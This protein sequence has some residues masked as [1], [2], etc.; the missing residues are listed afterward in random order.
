MKKVLLPFL[1]I[2][3]FLNAHLFSQTGIDRPE[4]WKMVEDSEY[5]KSVVKIICKEKVGDSEF[6]IGSGSG[7]VI[8]K[9][10][11]QEGCPE[12]WY[13]GWILTAGHV[14]DCAL[15][16]IEFENG[17]KSKNATMLKMYNKD[18]EKHGHKE[19][20]AI[21]RAAIPNSIKP[22]KIAKDYPPLYSESHILGFGGGSDKVR[23]FMFKIGISDDKGTCILGYCM[24]GDSG[25]PILNENGEI[26]SL[27]SSVAYTDR[28]ERI[29]GAIVGGPTT[30]PS[31][32]IIKE[33]T[34]L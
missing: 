5:K 1:F 25:G 22:L 28:C 18:Y 13:Y 2:F 6:I 30:G 4:I 31:L 34:G 33:L 21:V 16:D 27:V 23:H 7:S 19:D 29:N 8:F 15:M 10:E 14:A 20:A 32:K 24:Q 3:F 11:N 17:K 9:E 26:I 12:G